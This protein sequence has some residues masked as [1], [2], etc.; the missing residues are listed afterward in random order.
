MDDDV[1]LVRMACGILHGTPKNRK[2]SLPSVVPEINPKAQRLMSN[3]T[4]V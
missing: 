3:I 4:S 1:A 2:V